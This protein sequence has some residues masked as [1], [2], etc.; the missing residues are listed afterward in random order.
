MEFACKLAGSKIIL[1][2]GHTKCGAVKGA[3]DDVKLGNLTGLLQKLK[4]AINTATMKLHEST[5]GNAAFVENVARLNVMQTLNEIPKRSPILS[6]LIEE[7]KVILVG[8]MYHV[9]TGVVEFYEDKVV[10]G[11]K[12]QKTEAVR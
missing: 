4:P 6:G 3:C 10:S 1:V 5:S 8:A 12:F 9:E 2:L 11:T 7:G